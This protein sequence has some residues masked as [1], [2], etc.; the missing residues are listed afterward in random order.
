MCLFFFGNILGL[1]GTLP[2]DDGGTVGG[3][4]PSPC[5]VYYHSGGGLRELETGGGGVLGALR[6]QGY[7]GQT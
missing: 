1:M 2:C 3:R 4:R 6:I 7:G 5:Q